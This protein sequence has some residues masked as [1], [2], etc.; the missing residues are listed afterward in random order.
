MSNPGDKTLA[1]LFLVT[2]VHFNDYGFCISVV[3]FQHFDGMLVPVYSNLLHKQLRM[4]RQKK[5]IEAKSIGVEFD[6]LRSISHSSTVLYLEQKQRLQVAL[7]FRFTTFRYASLNR[8]RR[9]KPNV[10]LKFTIQQ[11]V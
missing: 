10:K 8:T 1:P 3:W 2:S 9:R 6:L 7:R 11:E 4:K 5:E